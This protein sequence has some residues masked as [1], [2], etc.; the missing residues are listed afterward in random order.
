MRAFQSYFAKFPRRLLGLFPELDEPIARVLGIPWVESTPQ[1]SEVE[2]AKSETEEAAGKRP[3]HSRG[4]TQGR[5]KIDPL[6]K[7]VIE[8]HAMNA[9]REH[10]ETL[11]NVRDSSQSNPYDYVVMI[12][13]EEWRVEVKGTQTSG[14]GIL[15]TPREVQHA[16]EYVRTALFVVSDIV[17]ETSKAGPV[18][19]GGSI[20]ILHPWN[21]DE[22]ALKPTGYE[23]S[24]P[25][26][27]PK[28]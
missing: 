24:L 20:T 26:F 12:D 19:S 14:E 6:V 8:A 22:S 10:Y 25:S 1:R 3:R 9:A 15:L 27:G 13:G 16:R 4:R 7:A 18:A 2:A 23:Y 11:G 21:L 28:L 17:I 5:G